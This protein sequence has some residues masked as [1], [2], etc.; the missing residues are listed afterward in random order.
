MARMVALLSRLTALTDRL[1][2]QASPCGDAAGRLD[3]GVLPAGAFGHVTHSSLISSMADQCGSD[4]AARMRSAADDLE[5]LATRVATTA[6]ELRAA[7]LDL[8]DAFASVTCALGAG[9]S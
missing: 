7:S 6:H 9:G 1:E 3:A 2:S 5:A 4:M 8:A